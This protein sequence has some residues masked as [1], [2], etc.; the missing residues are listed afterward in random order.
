VDIDADGRIDLLSGSYV[1]ENMGP[2]H[3]YL[4]RGLRRGRFAPGE[5]LLNQ[6][7]T[8]V[9]LATDQYRSIATAPHACDW[10]MDG[11]L[12]LLIGSMS[13]EVCLITNNGTA[14]DYRFSATEI[15]LE[16]G[17]RPIRVPG[18]ESGPRTADWDGDGV[19]D[20]LVSAA[21]GSVIF[22]RN[23][24]TNEDR[25]LAEGDFL[26]GPAMWMTQVLEHD[27]DPI[28]GKGARIHIVDWNGDGKLDLLKGDVMRYIR[29]REGLSRD[30]RVDFLEAREKYRAADRSAMRLRGRLNNSS[31]MGSGSPEESETISDEYFQMLQLWSQRL[32]EVQTFCDSKVSTGYVWVYIR[33]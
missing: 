7:G 17:G 26:I 11:D 22:F 21:D 6:S 13:G 29:E 12:D 14:E 4:F 24:G 3:I 5:L 18:G 31:F 33:K 19:I 30:E 9:E 23:N 10:D 8:P 27:K 32:K 20:L 16:A 28:P 25:I 15:V 2:G 1:S